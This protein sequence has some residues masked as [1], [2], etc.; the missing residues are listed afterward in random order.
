M[1]RCSQKRVVLTALVGLAA[2][3]LQNVRGCLPLSISQP[4]YLV[5]AAVAG[6]VTMISLKATSI[7]A[8]AVLMFTYARRATERV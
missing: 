7:N 4:Q 6:M 3:V 8:R 5:R 2:A 1:K